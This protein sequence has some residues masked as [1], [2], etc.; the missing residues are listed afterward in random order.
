M[1]NAPTQQDIEQALQSGAITQEQANA[2][3][4]RLTPGYAPLLKPAPVPT[5]PVFDANIGAWTDPNTGEPLPLPRKPN[6]AVPNADVKNLQTGADGAGPGGVP[7][8]AV[9]GVPGA[10]LQLPQIGIMPGGR[11]GLTPAE[12]AYMAAQGQQAVAATTEDEAAIAAHRAIAESVA[13]DTKN[14]AA[15][16]DLAQQQ[17]QQRQQH[18]EERR[19]VF[20]QQFD[21]ANARINDELAK[22]QAAGIDPNRYYMNQ[23]TGQKILGA[24]AVGLGALG[25]SPLGP[26]GTRGENVSLKIM[27]DAISRD[28]DAQKENMQHSVEVLGKRMGWNMNSMEHQDAM[29][30]AEAESTST[31]YNVAIGQVKNKLGMYRDNAQAQALATNTIRGLEE[32]RDNRLDTYMKQ[33]LALADKA[34]QVTGPGMLVKLPTGQVVTLAQYNE[35]QK[36]GL[37]Q[38]T[39]PEQQKVQAETIKAASQAQAERAKAARGGLTPKEIE[40]LNAHDNAI[41]NIDH[42]LELRKRHGGGALNVPWNANDRAEAE[43]Y[44]ARTQEALTAALGRTNKQL[45]DRTSHLIPDQPLMTTASGIIGQDP[46]ATRLLA[47]KSMMLQ[48]KRRLQA[49]AG[50]GVSEKSPENPAGGEKEE[51]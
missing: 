17:F 3:L 36:A 10:E 38:A 37:V 7:G 14:A 47:A 21:Q 32:N 44:A 19:A 34:Y 35:L 11:R 29:L 4:G 42:L 30:R 25:A 50:A 6:A 33:R 28:I 26:H 27:N 20:A 2:D 43:A 9:P 1:N 45:L 41:E 49:T 16:S 8:A 13:A 39:A 22:V 5:E 51:E 40:N 23:S 46:V 31:A 24:I 18:L 12:R 48:E 15:Q